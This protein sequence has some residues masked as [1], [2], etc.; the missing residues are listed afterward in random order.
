MREF[1]QGWRRKAGLATLAMACLLTVAWMR[2][3]VIGDRL[4]VASH[5]L[6]SAGGGVEWQFDRTGD[7]IDWTS[8]PVDPDGIFFLF[9]M[10]SQIRRTIYL[11]YWS[12]VLP[13]TLLS[14]WLL[15]IKPRPAKSAK[16]SSHA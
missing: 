4:Q 9:R 11:S 13:L 15:L 1:F 14:A 5:F 12:L 6:I 8:A 10:G 16:E 3:F 7:L 2:S